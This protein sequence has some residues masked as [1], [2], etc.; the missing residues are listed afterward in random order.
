MP[1]LTVENYGFGDHTWLGSTRGIH[2][3]RT[4][5]LDPANFTEA[6]HFPEGYIPS[7]TPITMTADVAGP[8][9]PAGELHGFLLTDQL[10]DGVFK[11]AVPLLDNGRVNIAKLPESGFTAPTP[12]NDKTTI[13]FV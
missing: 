9:D 1:K 4:V 7:G 12:E 13:V 5:N 8:Y 6:T 3:A 2:N 11:I 10:T